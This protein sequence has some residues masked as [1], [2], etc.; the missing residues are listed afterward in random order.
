[1]RARFLL[2]AGLLGLLLSPAASAQVTEH[3]FAGLRGGSTEAI[4]VEADSLEVNEQ[5]TQRVSVFRGNVTV[6][7]AGTTLKA[8][9]ITIYSPNGDNKTGKEAFD[10]IEASGKVYVRSG[11][12]VATGDSA[13][14]DAKNQTAVL[15]GNVVLTQGSNV[16][17]GDRLTIDL[18]SGRARV[19]QGPGGRIKGIFSPGSVQNKPGT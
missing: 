11:D 12:Q 13:R 10:R 14:F 4:Q 6:N 5:P 19:D 17:T 7:R 2:A 8:A 16:I 1:M 9:S 3:I 18:N 15:S